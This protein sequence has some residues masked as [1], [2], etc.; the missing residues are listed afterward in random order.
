MIT[1]DEAKRQI[2]LQAHGL[3]FDGCE[4]AFDGPVVAR[5]DTRFAYGE[6]RIDVIGFLHGEIVV[7][8]CTDRGDDLHVINSRRATSH[9]INT[10]ARWLSGHA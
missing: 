10:F 6:Q 7:L 3:D 4:A 9:E 5:E 8:T 2:N 1:W